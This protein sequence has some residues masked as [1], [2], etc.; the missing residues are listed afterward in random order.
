MQCDCKKLLDSY[1]EDIVLSKNVIDLQQQNINKMSEQIDYANATIEKSLKLIKD[2]E[3]I[4][5]KMTKLAMT[6]L[7]YSAILTRQFDNI[8]KQQKFEEDMIC[9][10][11]QLTFDKLYDESSDDC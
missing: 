5:T 1:T 7:Q 2:T 10:Y 6:A 8:R 11:D 9:N 4:S 3:T